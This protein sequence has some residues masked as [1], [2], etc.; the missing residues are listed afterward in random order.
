MEHECK[1]QEHLYTIPIESSCSL[2]KDN[3]RTNNEQ[4]D[5]NK[6]TALLKKTS[7]RTLK[8]L[9]STELSSEDKLFKPIT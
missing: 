3:K 8:G 4:E 7:L 5:T 6:I 1:G 9:T 2:E